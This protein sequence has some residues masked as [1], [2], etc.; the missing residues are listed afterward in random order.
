MLEGELQALELK[1][2]TWEYDSLRLDRSTSSYKRG[3]GTGKFMAAQDLRQ[4]IATVR[5][6]MAKE[7][8]PLIT[9][10]NVTT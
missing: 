9:P 7:A 3:I 10:C 6:R 4:Y 2:Q 5:E 1:A 8:H